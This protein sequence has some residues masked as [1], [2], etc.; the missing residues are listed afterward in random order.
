MPFLIG[1]DEAGYG[2]NLGPLVITATLWEL[3]EDMPPADMWTA[4]QDVVTSKL[5][6]GDRRLHIAD[7]KH[8]Y[9]SG[10]SIRNL[11]RGVLACLQQA[12]DRPSNVRSLGCRLATDAFAA[13]Y[14][15]A[16]GG[17]G[18][19]ELPLP[20][21]ATPDD[22]MQDSRRLSDALQTAGIR[23]CQARSAILFAPEFNRRVAEHN[24]KG[25]VLSTETLRLVREAVDT[26]QQPQPTGWIVCDKHGG[27]NRYDDLIADAFDGALV[28]RGTESGPRSEYRLGNMEFCFRTKAEE[29][30]PVAVSSMVA[31]Y[32]REVVM[33][34]F[35]AF[36]QSHVP[37]LKPTKG[38]P[39]DAARFWEDI[40]DVCQK[41][42]VDKTDIWRCR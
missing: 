3:P 8:V 29:L 41:L 34:Q 39:V 19:D 42:G 20:V 23:F 11:E 9:S 15:A 10:K 33:Q 17:P 1:T 25:V 40:A 22:L 18:R 12:G 26:L 2:P 7:S 6:R 35:N 16:I 14:H 24:S 38:Y 21:A 28:F 36:W 37:E 27:R 30:L 4:L 13:D 32:T 5:S 31:K